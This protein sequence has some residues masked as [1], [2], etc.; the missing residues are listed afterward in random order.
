MQIDDI[1]PTATN[2]V[3]PHG[4]GQC[5]SGRGLCVAIS[6]VRAY[7]GG[8]SGVWRS[9][10][11]GASWWHPEWRPASIGGPT[12]P[13]ALLPANVFDIVI[14][15]RNPDVVFAAANLDARSQPNDGVYRS[16]DGAVTWTKV[17]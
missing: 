9:D 5:P 7:V 4:S 8:A 14:D 17:H 1:S 13:G 3:S 10:D 15:P 2:F 11:G 6:G 16:V 12:T